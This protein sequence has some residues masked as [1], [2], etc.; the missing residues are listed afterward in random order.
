MHTRGHWAQEPS[1]NVE[2]WP[3]GRT[4]GR[5]GRTP[6]KAGG[7]PAALPQPPLPCSLCSPRP[8]PISALGSVCSEDSGCCPVPPQAGGFVPLLPQRLTLP[9]C[10]ALLGCP[11]PTQQPSP[12]SSLVFVTCPPLPSPVP[13]TRPDSHP[14]TCNIQGPKVPDREDPVF[15]PP[16]TSSLPDLVPSSQGPCATLASPAGVSA[17]LCEMCPLK[18]IC[19]TPNPPVPE[20]VTLLGNRVSAHLTS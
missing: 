16:G 6:A 15:C 7:P 2:M 4:K 13:P 17:A 8:S 20:P 19:L 11:P 5:R 10:A 9:V 1:M 18:K 14:Q 3:D 12:T